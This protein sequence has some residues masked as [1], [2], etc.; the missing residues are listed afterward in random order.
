MRPLNSTAAVVSWQP[1]SS[2][3]RNGVTSGYRLQLSQREASFRFNVT[4]NSS[5]TQV[6]LKNLTAGA[7]FSIQ[8]AAVNEIGTGPLSEPVH[9]QMA[10]DRSASGGGAVNSRQVPTAGG[11]LSQAWFIATIGGL[12]FLLL[13]TLVVVICWRRRREKKALGNLTGEYLTTTREC[14]GRVVSKA[15]GLG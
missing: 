15:D 3:D 11:L 9:F 8:L 4:V 10:A 1:P 12:L 5:T 13:T 14:G 6:I 2:S 7:G